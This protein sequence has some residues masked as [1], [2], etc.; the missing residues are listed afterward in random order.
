MRAR[1]S[2][3]I[4]TRPEG[5]EPGPCDDLEVARRLR[6]GEILAW[7]QGRYE[8][9]PRALGNRSLLAEPFS[10]ETHARLNAIKRREGFRPIAPIVLED[11][12]GR[13]FEENHPS[14]HMLYFQRARTS[15]LRA[16]THVDGS[17]RAQTVTREQN[18]R[19]HDLL[20]AFRAG[21][22]LRR[23][24]QHLAQFQRE[25][26]YQQAERPRQLCARDGARRIRR[27]R[28]VLS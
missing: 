20:S 18:P 11:E 22:R 9:G 17:A 16:V 7:V 28:H 15:A 24:L 10:A 25:G 23:A 19:M 14:P 27:G 21:D 13:W 8:I 2:S 26:F 1:S 4:L 6:A 3:S 5:F 12:I